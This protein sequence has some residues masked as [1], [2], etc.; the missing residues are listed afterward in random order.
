M[1]ASPLMRDVFIETFTEAARRNPNLIFI[2][3]DFGAKALDVVREE[4]PRQF[5]H[6]GIAEQS[7]VDIGAGL[8][9]EGKQVF[10][11]A[12]GPFISARC[13][14]QIKSLLV[15]MNLPITLLGVGVGLG[16]DHATMTHF[17]L[18]DLACMRALPGM[19][20][21]TPCDGESTREMARFAIEDPALRYIRLDRQ[22]FPSVYGGRFAE[23]LQNGVAT[24]AA[25]EGLA[26]VTSGN[27]VHQAMQA[28][29]I[30]RQEGIDLG[31]IDLFRIKPMN[32]KAVLESLAPY[33]RLITL[34]EQC[35]DGGFGS[36]L[37]ECLSDQGR[38]VAVKRLGVPGLYRAQNG[39]RAHLHQL[40]GIS[41]DDTLCA[42]REA[43]KQV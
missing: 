12:M 41:L 15:T 9:M 39:N 1:A 19:E 33:S 22:P 24:V 42:A 43:A 26:I 18:E 40:Y 36:A 16:Y 8:A 20:I 35:L 17:V 5:L 32:H 29:E 30:L 34:E 4:L 2:S 11:Y 10:L 6:P 27:F 21:L 23:S 13:Y 37:L 38:S 3:A 7:M 14:E 28:R 25:G 31:V